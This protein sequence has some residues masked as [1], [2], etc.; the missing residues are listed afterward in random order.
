MLFSLDNVNGG[1]MKIRM[2]VVLLVILFT[3][4]IA[5]AQNATPLEI[6]AKFPAA[7]Q[8]LN[9]NNLSITKSPEQ[10]LLLVAEEGIP[11]LK[12][13]TMAQKNVQAERA[14]TYMANR[15]LA[16]MMGY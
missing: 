3:A 11:S 16:K 14:A 8:W 5:A 6:D 2:V 7:K 12:A 1:N 9:Q 13:R 10:A 15:Q 4:G